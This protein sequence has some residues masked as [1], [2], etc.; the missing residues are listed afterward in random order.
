M[1]NKESAFKLT[2][3]AV[4]KNMERGISC[5]E[6]NFY[7]VVKKDHSTVI[8]PDSQHNGKRV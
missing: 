3:R 6:K 5:N 7:G 1:Y 2:E 4:K 8:V